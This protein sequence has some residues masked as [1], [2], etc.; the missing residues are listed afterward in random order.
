MCVFVT[1]CCVWRWLAKDGKIHRWATC[2]VAFWFGDQHDNS[3]WFCH[4]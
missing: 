2:F 4:L 3:K 1:C